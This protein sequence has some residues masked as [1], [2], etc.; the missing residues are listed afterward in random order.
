MTNFIA[1]VG[2]HKKIDTGKVTVPC[3]GG[4]KY[5]D[6]IPSFGGHVAR[7]LWTGNKDRGVIKAKNRDKQY[8][9]LLKWYKSSVMPQRARDIIDAT[10]PS[11]LPEIMFKYI[12]HALI[13]A[14]VERWQPDTNTFQSLS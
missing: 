13:S 9:Q 5:D 1:H 7:E 11:H 14:F 10:G 8:R 6:V 4:P 2:T 3:P 12:D